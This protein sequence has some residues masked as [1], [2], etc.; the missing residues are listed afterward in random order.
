MADLRV[1]VAALTS[2]TAGGL[3]AAPRPGGSP[4][5]TPPADAVAR[6][7]VEALAQVAGDSLRAVLLF[8]SRLVNAEPSPFSAYDLVAVVDD[9]LPFYRR[10]HAAGFHPR[11]PRLLTLLARLLAPNVIS[12]DPSLPGGEIAKVMVLT[13]DDLERALSP[14]ARDHFLR[15]RLVQSTKI[16]LAGDASVQGALEALLAGARRDVLRWAGPWLPESFNALELARRML[17]VSYAAEVRPEAGG[18]ALAVF[19][20]QTSFLEQAYREVLQDAAREGLVVELP[21]SPRSQ[22]R[23]RLATPPSVW[24]ALAW[25]LYFARS[26]VRATARW[27]KHVLTFN[28]WLT[29]IQRKVERRTGVRVELTPLERRLPLLL[30][31]PKAVRVL[32]Q[33]G[34]TRG[35]GASQ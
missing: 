12:F 17:E 31:W 13:F 27:L 18:R 1:R 8:G 5:R 15:G 26:K 9:Y 11:S 10:L 24:S 3:E 22:P 19:G 30:L 20:A 23:W 34:A 28:D 21:R 29:Y 32:R 14:R 7:L 6:S 33:L 16:V 2:A 25:R 35:G 4:E